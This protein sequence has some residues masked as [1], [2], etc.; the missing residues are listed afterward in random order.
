MLTI[1]MLY[2][3]LQGLPSAHLDFLDPPWPIFC[4]RIERA[5]KAGLDPLTALKSALDNMGDWE[6]LMLRKALAQSISVLPITD[7]SYRQ[8]EALIALRYAGVASLAQL[9]RV[10]LQDPANTHKRLA[11]LVKKG[12]AMKFFRPGGIH[13]F[14]VPGPIERSLKVSIKELLNELTQKARE[15]GPEPPDPAEENRNAFIRASLTGQE[16]PDLPRS[17]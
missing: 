12:F 11:V 7:L 4:Q 15:A 17:P 5:L 14:A 3:V 10:L 13:Y 9:S 8:K 16:L 1:E 2:A 6:A